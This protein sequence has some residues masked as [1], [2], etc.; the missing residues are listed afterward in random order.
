MSAF[1]SFAFQSDIALNH[2]Q[3]EAMKQ[4]RQVSGSGQCTNAASQ[5]YQSLNSLDVASPVWRRPLLDLWQD[6]N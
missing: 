5:R 1:I 6:M 3:D 4:R 2:V